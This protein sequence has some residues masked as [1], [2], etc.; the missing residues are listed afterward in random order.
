MAAPQTHFVIAFVF[1][2]ILEFAFK[3][4]LSLEELFSI[5]FWGSL[6]DFVDHFTSPSYVKDIISVR[7]KRLLKGGDFGAPSVG[8]KIP[9]CWFHLWPGAVLAWL[10]GFGGLIVN[11]SFMIWIPF[12][13]W[14]QH[15]LT[16]KFQKNDGSYPHY[17]FIYP[18]LAKKWEKR[19]GYPIK[20][21]T[22]ILISTFLAFLV[23]IFEIVRLF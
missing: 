23:V 9:K 12:I 21:R 7:F 16:D 11:F 19:R 10:W 8:V 17:P 18:V 1:R 3:I 13:F 6:M 2:A 15:V 5:Y 14:F 4:K 20:S 22:E